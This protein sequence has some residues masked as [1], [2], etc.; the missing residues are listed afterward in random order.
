MGGGMEMRGMGDWF[1]GTLVFFPF[2]N[3]G[4]VS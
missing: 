2:K 3:T 1:G 4:G